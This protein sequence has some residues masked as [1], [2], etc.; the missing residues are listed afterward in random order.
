MANTCFTTIRVEGRLGEIRRFHREFCVDGKY[1]YSKIAPPQE[2]VWLNDTWGVNRDIKEEDCMSTSLTDYF[3]I[4]DDASAEVIYSFTS[5]WSGPF[6]FVVTSSTKFD[7]IFTLEE[8]EAQVGLFSVR[9]IREGRV[10]TDKDYDGE[11]DMSINYY[12]NSPEEAFTDRFGA[13]IKTE[14]DIETVY[15]TWGDLDE[16]LEACEEF[17]VVLPEDLKQK[18]IDKSEEE[19]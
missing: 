11:L 6:N 10:V 2:G 3:Y 1:T 8:D 12:K 18:I 17:G 14:E 5:P 9:M 15:N 13:F 19:I 4:S 16:Y 7:L